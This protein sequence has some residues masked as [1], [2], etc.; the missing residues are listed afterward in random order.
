MSTASRKNRRA[1]ISFFAWKIEGL[2][3]N[4]NAAHIKWLSFVVLV[5]LLLLPNLALAQEQIAFEEVSVQLWPEYDS[6]D[7]LVILNSQLQT[8]VSLP[9]QVK[10][11]IPGSVEKP[12]VVAVGETAQSVTDQGIDY[13]Y[14]KVGDWLEVSITATGP[15]IRIEY[16]DSDLVRD[17]N[18]RTYD[19]QWTGDYAVDT[20]NVSVLVPVDTTEIQT[21]PE[22]K[23]VFPTG[24]THT[25]LEWGTSGLA[26]G[27]P[28]PIK[29]TYTKTSDRLS[30]SGP[31]ETQVVDENTEGRVSLSNYLPY[32]LGGLGVLLIVGAGIYFW[33]TSQGKPKLRRRHRTRE[34]D[35]DED[36]VYCHQCGNRAQPGDRFCRTCGTRLRRET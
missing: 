16:Y 29:V 23:E 18:Q 5:T 6:P 33:Q 10:V 14:E 34:Q 19:Y 20:F 7:M 25:F 11:R 12:Y 9:A 26:A 13:S 31:L 24:T 4:I 22:M 2:R 27:E 32:I 36:N 3:R 30:M 35:D 15:A 21:V 28:L 1:P 17:G 8:A